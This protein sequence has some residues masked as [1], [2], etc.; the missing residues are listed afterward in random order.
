M[1]KTKCRLNSRR[2]Q[3][4]E[5][6]VFDGKLKALRAFTGKH[7]PTLCECGVRALELGAN[8]GNAEDK[9][10]VVRVRTRAGAQRAE[11]SFV[12]EDVGVMRY[13]ALP[14]ASAAEMKAVLRDMDAVNRR[15]G[16]DGTFFIMVLDVETGV[17]NNAPVGFSKESTYATPMPYRE[18]L[19]RNLNEGIVL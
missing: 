14:P 8:I 12:A 3:F 13:D 6:A 9:F 7:R 15:Q 19:F 2:E 4:P 18:M 17:R 10:L 11:L 16:S 1:H 5:L